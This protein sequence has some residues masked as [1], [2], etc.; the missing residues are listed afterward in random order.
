MSRA[1]GLWRYTFV[2]YHANVTQW[3]I[4]FDF[5]QVSIHPSISPVLDVQPELK[6]QNHKYNKSSCTIPPSPHNA[7]NPP[8]HHA[9]PITHTSKFSPP[10]TKPSV[11]TRRNRLYFPRLLGGRYHLDG[12]LFCSPHPRDRRLG[13]DLGMD[14]DLNLDLDWEGVERAPVAPSMA[15]R[16]EC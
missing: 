8:S 2:Q 6:P 5:E 15:R 7:L 13:L 4:S 11:P 12:E 14:L 10:S 9:S 16:S 1:S 3:P